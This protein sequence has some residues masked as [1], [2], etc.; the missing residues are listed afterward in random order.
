MDG[1]DKLDKSRCGEK[2]KAPK[3]QKS[4]VVEKLQK[5]PW[6]TNGPPPPEWIEVSLSALKL[7]NLIDDEREESCSNG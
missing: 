7:T 4:Q 3:Q 2:R 5:K 6:G 1:A